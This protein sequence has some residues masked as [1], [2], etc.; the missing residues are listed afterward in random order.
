LKLQIYVDYILIWLYQREAV[1]FTHKPDA[2][3]YSQ[4]YFA[5][6]EEQEGKIMVGSREAD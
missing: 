1:D 3:L 6:S 5:V 4:E 2:L